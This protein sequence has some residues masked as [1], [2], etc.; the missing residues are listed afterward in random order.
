MGQEKKPSL[1]VSARLPGALV[2]R[3]DFVAKNHEGDVKNRSD[4]VRAAL[5][6]WL[7]GQ[8]TRLRELGLDVKKPR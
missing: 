7:P 8:E 2:A 3:A 1:M 6:Q 4:A 5:E